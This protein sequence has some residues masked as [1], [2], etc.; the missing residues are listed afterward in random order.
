MGSWIAKSARIAKTKLLVFFFNKAYYQESTILIIAYNSVVKIVEWLDGSFESQK[1][2][3]W[4]DDYRS[5]SE[6]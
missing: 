5:L 2:L 6:Y 4:F 1:A 3:Q